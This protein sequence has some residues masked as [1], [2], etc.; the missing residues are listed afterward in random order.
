MAR[1]AYDRR[2]QV[3]RRSAYSPPPRSTTCCRQRWR[4][5]RVMRVSRS[6]GV[7]AAQTPSQKRVPQ[8]RAP[9]AVRCAQVPLA[10]AELVVQVAPSGWGGPH[11]RASTLGP[12]H[13]PLEQ[14]VSRAQA[15]PFGR[16]GPHT[17]PTQVPATHSASCSQIVPSVKG[18]PHLLEAGSQNVEAAHSTRQN[19]G[20]AHSRS[21]RQDAPSPR[22]GRHN[23]AAA[24]QNSPA[25]H[26]M[27]QPPSGPQVCVSRTQF[28]LSQNMSWP[29]HGSPIL[30]APCVI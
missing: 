25:A 13:A 23:W 28:E 19:D 18:P 11:V 6:R 14:S 20:E 21:S 1:G 2:A 5:S 17:L 29:S 15:A 4:A 30:R 8:V 7:R 26:E 3:G 27:G 10:H 24:S 16:R 9:R 22:T 12:K